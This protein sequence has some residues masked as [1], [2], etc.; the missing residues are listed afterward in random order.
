MNI[1]KDFSSKTI[2]LEPDYEGE[3]T[4]TLVSSNFNQGDRKSVLYL[5]GYVDYFFQAHLGEKF[6]ANSFDFYALDLRKYG[7]SLLP[8]QHPNYCR[9]LA[10][11]HEEISL[12]IR[13]INDA[14]NGEII[15]MGHSTGGLIASN[16]MNE[17]AD[18]HLIKGLILNS[19]FL[20]FNQSGFKKYMVYLAALIMTRF[21]E[22]SKV[23]GALSPAYVKSIHKDYY[24][25][26]DF[27][28]KW[29]PLE[30]F[31]TYFRWLLAIRSAHKKLAASNIQVPVLV[32]HSSSSAKISKYSE[33][34]KYND[35]VLDVS[36]IKKIGAKLG[37]KVSL[38]EVENAMHDIFLSPKA[39]REKA[40]EGMFSW[41]NTLKSNS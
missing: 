36:D 31:P 10:E 22:F 29:K 23:D 1:L 25:E 37:D 17:S 18:R 4:A 12:A 20:D 14:S 8:H 40:F 33:E 26:W 16:Y 15:L 5:H 9:D 39:I 24:G 7:R 19:P 30:G 21:S 41:L 34:A 35:I 13:H 27:N 11:Y 28:H 2:R 32:M 6:N 3:V 38:L